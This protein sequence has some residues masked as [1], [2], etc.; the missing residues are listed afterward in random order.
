MS[1][2]KFIW[3]SWKI[4]SK[5]Q[6]ENHILFSLLIF[7]FPFPLTEF[8]G[9]FT[10]SLFEFFAFSKNWLSVMDFSH[11]LSFFYSK[12]KKNTT[13]WNNI[14][15]NFVNAWGFCDTWQWKFNGIAMNHTLPYLVCNAGAQVYT[16]YTGI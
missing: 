9:A 5:Q 10:E 16:G 13:E 7:S 14:K 1:M 11:C 2:S 15:H 3:H 6:R 12:I 4:M 8:F